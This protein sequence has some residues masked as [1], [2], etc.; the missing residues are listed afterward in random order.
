MTMS[1][2]SPADARDVID[3]YFS[4]LAARDRDG[5]L[6]VLSPEIV[7]TYHGQ[8]VRLPWAGRYEGVDGFD[9]F[10]GIVAAHFEV[11]NVDRSA[12]IADGDQVVVQCQGTWLAKPTGREINAGMVNV[13]SVDAGRIS[14]YEV[15]ADTEA[16]AHALRDDV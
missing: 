9:E 4:L 6:E 14:G 5:L 1:D 16:F 3:R 12:Y 11:V 15:Y 10:L 13:F 8:D 7:V 2:A